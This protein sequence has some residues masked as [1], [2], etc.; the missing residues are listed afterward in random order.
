MFTR[1]AF[2]EQGLSDEVYEVIVSDDGSAASAEQLCRDHF[3]WVVYTKG[4]SQGAAA[5]RNHGATVAKHPWLVFIDDDCLPESGL[6]SA[7]FTVA[8]KLSERDRVVLEGPTLR[9][10]EPPSLLWE[11]PHNPNGN[12]NISANFVI[13]KFA[14]EQIGGFDESFRYAFEDIEFFNRFRLSGG[15]VQFVESAIVWH[16]L[17]LITSS[18][19]LAKRWEGKVILSIYQGAPSATVMWRL[20]WHV[21]RVIQSRFRGAKFSAENARAALLFLG[22]WLLVIWST[23]TWVKK[24]TR[25]SSASFWVD[26][27]N[28]CGAPPKHGF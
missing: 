16:P 13:S 26:Y 5:N 17:R 21:L 10:G 22:E 7:Y 24:W 2:Q 20:P 25:K 1:L 19:S 28:R 3:E 6:L 8:S 14:F 15:R 11:A 9:I 4:P 27:T 12:A 23:A 18:V